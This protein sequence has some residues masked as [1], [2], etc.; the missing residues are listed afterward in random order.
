MMNK[1]YV[2]F[3]FYLLFVIALAQ[4]PPDVEKAKFCKGMKQVLESGRHENFESITGAEK[5]S[6][7]LPVPGYTIHL[8]RFPIIYVDKDSRFVAKTNI[9]MDSLTAA[10]QLLSYR[11]YVMQCLDTAEWKPG[12]IITGDIAETPFFTEHQVYPVISKE[13]KLHVANVR[14]T[15]KV[16]SI[17]FYI[18]RRY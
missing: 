4:L 7:W 8:P 1:L 18:R 13:F 6:S 17:L 5:Q 2:F 14:L 9:N 12:E 15:D 10:A 3:V 16:Y 11:D